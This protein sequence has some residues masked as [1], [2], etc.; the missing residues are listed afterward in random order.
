MDDEAYDYLN[1]CL[2]LIAKIECTQYQL[3]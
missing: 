1:K 3:N 2:K